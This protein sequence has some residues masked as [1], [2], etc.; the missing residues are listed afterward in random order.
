MLYI[1]LHTLRKTQRYNLNVTK[2]WLQYCRINI[3]FVNKLCVMHLFL[4]IKITFVSSISS[5]LILQH[6]ST[7]FLILLCFLKKD[8][9]INMILCLKND[10][11]IINMRTYSILS[12][13]LLLNQHL[14][15]SMLTFNNKTLEYNYLTLNILEWPI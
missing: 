14:A 9:L 10:R 6:I 2:Y 1:N 8:W 12:T 13:F 3:E 4:F 7:C 5:P 15:F 11:Y